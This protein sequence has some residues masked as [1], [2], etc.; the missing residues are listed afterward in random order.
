[1]FKDKLGGQWHTKF[2]FDTFRRESATVDLSDVEQVIGLMQTQ[3]EF[4]ALVY[5]LNN[6]SEIEFDEFLA[7]MD[8]ETFDAAI[9]SFWESWINFSPPRMRSALGRMRDAMKAE[10][11]NAIAEAERVIDG[12]STVTTP[13]ESSE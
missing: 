1:M 8:G 10:Q 7:R 3:V 13:P 12:L 9:E 2:A 4:L 11:A 5:R 6:T